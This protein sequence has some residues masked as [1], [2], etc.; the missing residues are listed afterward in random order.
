[1]RW[2]V[3]WDGRLVAIV[4]P[5]GGGDPRGRVHGCGGG[6]GGGGGGSMS[7]YLLV[8]LREFEVALLLQEVLE[9]R[10]QPLTAQPL[11]EVVQHKHALKHTGSE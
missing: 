9:A 4:L 11:M 3:V 5:A 2:A 10:V 7:P 6:G 8:E 1:M